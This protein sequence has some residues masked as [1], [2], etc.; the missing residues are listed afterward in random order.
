M[1]WECASQRNLKVKLLKGLS[2]CTTV[3]LELKLE[4]GKFW[5]TE[6]TSVARKSKRTGWKQ[7]Y[8][9]MNLPA[10]AYREPC[11]FPFSL[12][13][14]S[15]M[16]SLSSEQILSLAIALNTYCTIWFLLFPGTFPSSPPL[17]AC[18]G[19]TSSPSAVPTHSPQ[20]PLAATTQVLSGKLHYPSIRLWGRKRQIKYSDFFLSAW[21][22][23]SMQHMVLA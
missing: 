4:L 23:S 2:A 7:R 3:L 12:A 14:K 11:S 13:L 21:E 22:Q 6:L 1:W 19:G 16:W 17:Q 15:A 9:I 20:E 18:C 10:A 8:M 5:K